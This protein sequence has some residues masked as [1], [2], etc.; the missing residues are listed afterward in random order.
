ME[1]WVL[2]LPPHYISHRQLMGC[3]GDALGL[4]NHSR[5]WSVWWEKNQRMY[6]LNV[7]MRI[8]AI[9]SRI[10]NFLSSRLRLS[11]S[12][13]LRALSYP[14]GRPRPHIESSMRFRDFSRWERSFFG[15]IGRNAHSLGSKQVAETR[16]TNKSNAQTRLGPFNPSAPTD[17]EFCAMVTW[18]KGFDW[19]LWRPSNNPC[20]I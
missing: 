10:F 9:S 16:T 17:E 2:L 13:F 20:A 12:P 8:L 14:H 5:K 4:D 7:C 19:S 15:G 6:D 11:L 18:R 3:V 1:L